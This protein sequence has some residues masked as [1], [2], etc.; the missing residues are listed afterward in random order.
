MR[1]VF[2]LSKALTGLVAM[3]LIA[4]P[5]AFGSSHQVIS[6]LHDL[7]VFGNE[8]LLGTHEGLYKYINKDNFVKIGKESPD[9][10]G[11][12]I[13]G[14]Q[15]FASGHPAKGSDLPNPV[16]LLVSSD[17]GQTWKK[18]S[19]Q[20]KVDFH[21]LEVGNKQIYGVNAGTGDLLYS[22]NLGKNWKN[23]GANQFTD[24]AIDPQ[25]TGTALALRAGKLFTSSNSFNSVKELKL[26]MVFTSLDW[27]SKKLLAT[28]GKN[29]LISRDSGESWKK[30]NSFTSEITSISQSTTLIVAIVGNEVLKSVDGGKKFTK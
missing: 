29:L 20:G 22:A 26:P 28:S 9:V 1:G 6:H 15:I 11:L 27:N 21:F 24:I 13:L 18:V 23:L 19:L 30:I 14:N 25:V 8:I 12:S 10:M 4:T 5:A 17:K 7:R 3:S 16:G 2:M